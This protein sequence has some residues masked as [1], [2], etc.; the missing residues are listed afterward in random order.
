MTNKELQEELAKY[1]DNMEVEIEDEED[2]NLS[3]PITVVYKSETIDN[4]I[5]FAFV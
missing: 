1:P 4:C 3:S 2:N 5:V